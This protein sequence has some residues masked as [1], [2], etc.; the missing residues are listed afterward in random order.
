MRKNFIAI[1]M[2]SIQTFA[3]AQSVIADSTIEKGFANSKLEACEMAKTNAQNWVRR[4][5]ELVPGIQMSGRARIG[6]CDCE[7]KKITAEIE[8]WTCTVEASVSP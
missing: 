8:S 6:G 1:G 3:L 7:S 2:L 5:L 4:H